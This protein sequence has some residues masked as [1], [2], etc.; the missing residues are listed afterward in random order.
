[1]RQRALIPVAAAE[2]EGLRPLFLPDRPGPLTGLHAIQHGVGECRVDRWPDPRVAVVHVG[3]DVQIAGDPQALG[4]GD[5][6]WLEPPAAIDAP[7]GFRAPLRARFAGLVVWERI[8]A[9]ITGPA[10]VAAPHGVVL[11]RLGPE[12]GGALGAL[13]RDL[14]WIAQSFETPTQTARAGFCFGA[15]VD[16]R[17]ASVASPFLMG[18]RFE[19][20]G[21]VTLE[22]FRG[23]GLSPA[24]AADAV[25][26]IRKRGRQ[27]TWSTSPDN[28]ASL[29]VAAKLGAEKERD[30]VLYAAP[31]AE[32][33]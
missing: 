14:S 32:D 8:I 7:V 15:F 23:R 19:D 24:C 12:D 27:P 28:R 31:G 2:R 4:A 30:D 3:M 26:D 5:L 29:R 18:E 11:R 13:P 1:M 16:G 17:L 10:R 25:A 22:E 9:R 20:I 33:S 21:V 6:D